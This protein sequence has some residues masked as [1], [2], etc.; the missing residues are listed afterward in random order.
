M[1][2]SFSKERVV[3]KYENFTA[4]YF[5]NNTYCETSIPVEYLRGDFSSLEEGIDQAVKF[6]EEVQ[7]FS[8][9]VDE[10]FK[11]MI[12]IENIEAFDFYQWEQNTI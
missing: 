7:M 1:I 11:K 8:G 3:L 5:K 4:I 6:V 9:S 10:D 2:D 12:P